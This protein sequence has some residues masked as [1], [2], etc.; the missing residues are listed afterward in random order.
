[1]ETKERL[2]RSVQALTFNMKRIFCYLT[3]YSLVLLFITS[4]TSPVPEPGFAIII[5]QKSYEEARA[6]VEA[7]AAAIAADGLKTVVI[8]DEW[9]QPDSIRATLMKLYADS[10]HPIEGA[11]FIGDIPI[12]MIR[13]AQHLT[14]A[15]K[16]DQMRYAWEDSSI[17][18]DRFYDDFDLRF[19]F[20]K[21]DS[22]HSNYFYYSL[23]AD[24]PQRLQPEIYTGRI[25]PFEHA[26]KYLDLKK[27]LKKAVKARSGSNHLDKLLF[28]GGHGY[29]SES[30]LARMDEKIMLHEQFPNSSGQ[31]NAIGYIDHSMDEHIK[32]KLVSELQ[33][34]DLDMAILHHHGAD[35]TQY[36]NGMPKVDN[37]NKQID[38]VK[39][40]LR[41][42]MRSAK[43]RGKSESEARKYYMDKL[44][45]PAGWFEGSFDEEK[46]AQDSLYNAELDIAIQEIGNFNPKARFIM[47]DACFNGA[48]HLDSCIASAYLFHEG[49]TVALHANTV[50]VLQDKWANELT[51]LLALGMSV[52][53]WSKHVAYLESH[54]IGDPTFRFHANDAGNDLNMAIHQKADDAAYWV[55]QL[56]SPLAEVQ[57]LALIRLF[58]LEHDGLSELL[59]E[60]FKNNRY[61][62]VRMQCLKLLSTFNDEHFIECLKLACND[63]NEF[64]QRQAIYLI[65]QVGSVRLLPSLVAIA[66]RNNVANRLEFNVKQ[67]LS[68]FAKDEVMATFDS[69]FDSLNHFT[70]PAMVKDAIRQSLEY[71]TGRWEKNAAELAD[72][73]L[74]AKKKMFRIRLLR[75]Y[76]YHPDVAA[77]CEFARECEKENLQVAMLEALGWF[78]LSHKKD[79]IIDT[80]RELL[81]DNKVPKSVKNEALKTLGRLEAAWHR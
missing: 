81:A 56:R 2:D 21:Q 43:R 45:V 29:I 54:I 10:D 68:V 13:D 40:Y 70:K 25:K 24:S 55:N 26:D 18:S 8:I 15:F 65:G 72:T 47:L 39:Y 32:D 20:L 1:M 22:I 63:S 75:N 73:T 61:A 76:N 17:P 64:V 34:D 48:F 80:C 35:D 12:P 78:N 67:A 58:E 19:D 31:Q 60:N 42:K 9:G 27:Y 53:N 7:Y 4:C 23:R 28:F 74:T 79:Q 44:D 14:T 62:T 38:G 41:S 50:N 51:G 37:V 46:I 3:A 5:D 6:E 52:G 49:N 36:L 16:M 57:S 69:M 71:N 30:L 77:F 11:V 33:R 66:M 59:L